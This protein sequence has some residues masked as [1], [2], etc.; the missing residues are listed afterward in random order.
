MET[1]ITARPTPQ[2]LLQR[3]PFDVDLLA[4]AIGLSLA[5]LIH[6]GIIPRVVF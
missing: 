5:T 2:R 6:F 3:L 1:P 4:I